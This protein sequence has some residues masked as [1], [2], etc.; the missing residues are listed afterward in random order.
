MFQLRKHLNR[1]NNNKKNCAKVKLIITSQAKLSS[2][3]PPLAGSST[4]SFILLFLFSWLFS[5][6]SL[7]I[8]CIS[9][10]LCFLLYSWLLRTVLSNQLFKHENTVTSQEIL[11]CFFPL[12]M[13]MKIAVKI[14]TTMETRTPMV[15]LGCFS[16]FSMKSYKKEKKT[17][18][19]DEIHQWNNNLHMKKDTKG[20]YKNLE[21]IFA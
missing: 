3:T 14:T 4:T 10:H 7:I 5:T 19:F 12:K 18:V 17:Q 2:V 15:R 21:L 6:A 8:W 16:P 1:K 20:T 13:S 11:T 9:S